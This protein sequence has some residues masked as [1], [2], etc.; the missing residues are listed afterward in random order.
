MFRRAATAGRCTELCHENE[1]ETP[2][3][4]RAA[5]SPE[6]PL[7][8]SELPRSNPW[9]SFSPIPSAPRKRCSSSWPKKL[10]IKTGRN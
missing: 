1:C 10:N 2:F 8:F 5:A 3:A 7:L 9:E 6:S 4:A